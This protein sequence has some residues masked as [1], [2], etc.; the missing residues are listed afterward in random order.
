VAL[1]VIQLSTE[2]PP[3]ATEVGVA[4][5]VTVGAGVGVVT[6]TTADLE[7]EPPPLFVQ[8]RTKVVVA[9]SG[10]TWAVPLVACVPLQPPEAVQES[11]LLADHV[12]VEEP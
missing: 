5:S 6:V 3:E 9:A 8:P 1:L 12:S 7:A 10:P 4:V 11:A 2:V